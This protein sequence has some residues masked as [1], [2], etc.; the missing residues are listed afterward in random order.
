[1]TGGR[2][3]EA[4]GGVKQSCG[5]IPGSSESRLISRLGLSQLLRSEVRRGGFLRFPPSG[6]REE[7]VGL[8]GLLAF[9]GCL[10]SRNVVC[11]A[12]LWRE[13]SGLG[14]GGGGGGGVV[15]SGWK[16]IISKSIMRLKQTRSIPSTF[17]RGA[18][19]CKAAAVREDTEHL[20]VLV[21]GETSSSTSEVSHHPPTAR[22]AIPSALL[23]Y[24]QAGRWQMDVA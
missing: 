4:T 24:V 2:D 20:L 17:G 10:L 9:H 12:S 6:R 16:K 13:A 14:D 21:E 15:P 19:N 1:M 7:S 23:I 8:G 3:V 18:A 11:V 5:K 22:L